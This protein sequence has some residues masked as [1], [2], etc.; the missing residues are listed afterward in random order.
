MRPVSK[1][2]ILDALRRTGH[3][4][5]K[6]LGQNFL[7]DANIARKEAQLAASSGLRVAVEVGPGLGSLTVW[8]ADLFDEVVAL[9]IDHRLIA[10]LEAAL[11]ARNI[12]NVRVEHVDALADPLPLER[13]PSALVANLPYHSGSQL[14][15]RLIEEAWFLERAVVMV[16]AEFA[17]RIVTP[18]GRRGCSALG[19]RLALNV[20]ARSVARVPPRV[21]YPQP[22]V[23]S[24]IVVADRRP[25]P[26][27]AVEPATFH[28]TVLAV[29]HG[30]ARRRQML[31]RALGPRELEGLA[32]CGIDPTR[33]AE[34]LTLDEWVALGRS[35]A[36]M[37]LSCP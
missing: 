23:W 32:R 24:K 27:A 31:R 13:R 15:V 17:D 22:T 2:E 9:E 12:T 18:A 11:A 14:L 4:P 20:E 10:P 33:R 37:E 25:E 21:F 30:F 16:Q 26:L 1:H 34:S 5:S 19:V 3:E 35:I 29:R 36:E 7:L 8:L 6:A 28:A